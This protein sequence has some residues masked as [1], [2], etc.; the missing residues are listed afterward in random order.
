MPFV[1]LK[2]IVF[3]IALL[4]VILVDP[5]SAISLVAFLCVG[6]VF[7]RILF[8]TNDYSEYVFIFSILTI[9]A[10]FIYWTNLAVFPL[11]Y[12]CTGA[13][14]SGTDD[15]YFFEEAVNH[16]VSH[17]GDRS[18]FM[19]NYSIFLEFFHLL[20]SKYKKTNL[21]DLMFVNILFHA[22]IPVFSKK[23]TFFFTNNVKS[24]KLAFILAVSSPF[25]IQHSLVLVRDGITACL[26]IGI[27]HFYLNKKYLLLLCFFVLLC[28]LRIVSGGLAILFLVGYVYYSGNTWRLFIYG[29]C[30]A[31]L[32]FPFLP[33]ILLDLQRSGVLTA[34]IFREELFEYIKEGSGSGSGAVTILSLPTYFRIPLGTLYYIGT[35]FLSLREAFSVS[36]VYLWSKISIGYSFFFLFYIVFLVRAFFADRRHIL[37]FLSFAFM[38]LAML[39]SQISLEVRHKT[40]IMPLLFVIVAISYHTYCSKLVRQISYYV[41]GMLVLLQLSFNILTFVV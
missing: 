31:V 5:L 24:S 23:I 32:A 26:F 30:L 22:Y 10:I 15:L 29:V 21:I 38:I 2:N 1:K 33:L 16:G 6:L 35:P 25:L 39:F 4:F 27:F 19:H 11:H 3:Y 8:N 17:R 20:I 28:Y 7:H 12:G 9:I 18:M 37:T 34:G 36:A 13:E 40:M 41:L 14:I